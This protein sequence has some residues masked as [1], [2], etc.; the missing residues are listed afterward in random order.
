[1]RHTERYLL[2]V[3]ATAL[4]AAAEA[5]SQERQS[6]SRRI[7]VS[8]ADRKL[9]L[10]EGSRILRTYEVAVG[11]PATPSPAGSF[12]VVTLVVNP[13]WYKPRQVVPPGPDNPL[14]PR[15]IG[16]SRKG[17]GIHG[18]NSPRSIGGAKSHGCIRMRNTDVEELF[19][20]IAVGDTV[21]LRP[22]HAAELGEVLDSP[23][24]L[25]AER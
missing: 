13:T 25:L 16:L 18:T 21:E 7:V 20:L 23:A 11:A 5:Y 14:G 12:E 24:T 2:K 10:F 15:W 6:S 9:I 1:M 8:L 19:T 4:V 17:Y 22:E 3:L